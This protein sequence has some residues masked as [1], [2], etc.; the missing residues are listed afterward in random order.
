M[1]QCRLRL[2]RPWIFQP[3][4]GIVD[5]AALAVNW[6][7]LTDLMHAHAFSHTCPRIPTKGFNQINTCRHH[8]SIPYSRSILTGF[9]CSFLSFC[10]GHMHYLLSSSFNSSHSISWS[11]KIKKFLT[12]FVVYV[13]VFFFKKKLVFSRKWY[14]IIK[15]TYICPEITFKKQNKKTSNY[16]KNCSRNV[17]SLLWRCRNHTPVLSKHEA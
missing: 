16:N 6:S 11:L 1:R 4:I 8:S 7:P 15:I 9:G 10:L 13:Q 12:H 5:C 17:V 3:L 2:P 14:K